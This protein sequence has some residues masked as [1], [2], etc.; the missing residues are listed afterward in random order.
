MGHRGLENGLERRE[1]RGFGGALEKAVRLIQ[2]RAMVVWTGQGW[3][4][5]ENPGEWRSVLEVE[6][7]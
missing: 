4:G 5:G 7:S 3:W 1:A 2:E 6:L